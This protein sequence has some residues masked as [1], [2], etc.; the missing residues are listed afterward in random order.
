MLFRPLR[1]Y[2][3]AILNQVRGRNV[4]DPDCLGV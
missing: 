2:A 1:V 3:S 4:K